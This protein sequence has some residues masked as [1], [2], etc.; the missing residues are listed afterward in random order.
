MGQKILTGKARRSVKEQS[1]TE[2]LPS[3]AKRPN[4]CVPTVERR[5]HTIGQDRVTVLIKHFVAVATIA[6]MVR[7]KTFKRMTHV[8][9]TENSKKSH[10]ALFL[11]TKILKFVII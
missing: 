8:I 5:K 4:S 6:L 7:L 1:I 10:T 2:L 11:L 9:K 3:V